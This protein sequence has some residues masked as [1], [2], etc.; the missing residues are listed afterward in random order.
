MPFAMNVGLVSHYYVN[1]SMYP[2]E[3]TSDI[4]KSI[5]STINSNGGK[6]LTKA[7]VE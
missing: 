7:R 3:G 2:K 1:G 6:C 5:V 4:I